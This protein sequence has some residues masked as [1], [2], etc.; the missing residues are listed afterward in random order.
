VAQLGIQAAEALEHAHQ[1][2]VVHRDIK[3]GN[4]LLET[5]SPFMHSAGVD[6]SETWRLWV[7]DFGLAYCQSEAGLTI[8]HRDRMRVTQPRLDLAEVCPQ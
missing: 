2:G 8:K 4:L 7:T 5:S 3:P 1:L 6:G